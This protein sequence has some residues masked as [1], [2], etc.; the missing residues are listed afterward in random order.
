MWEFLLKYPPE[1]FSRGEI[2]LSGSAWLYAALVAAAVLVI[3]TLLRYRRAS[4]SLAPADRAVLTLARS[5]VAAILVLALFQPVLSVSNIVSERTTVA[6]LL[7]DSVSMRIADEDGAA[8]AAFVHSAFD[9]DTG[10]ISR[11]LARR[12]DPVFFRFSADLSALS[13]DREMQF[14][15]ARTEIG[16]ALE[17][18]GGHVDLQSL[19]AVVLVSDG[20]VTRGDSLDA[21]LSAYRA[22]DVPITTVG[23]G[24]PVF[25]KDVEVS[26]LSLPQRVLEGSSI[27]ADVTITQRG[28]D[29]ETV[30]LVIEDDGEPA[31]VETITFG[32]HQPVRTVR[33]RFTARDAGPRRLRFSITPAADETIV[34]NNARETL[35]DVDGAGQR[36]LY[37]EGEPRFELKF[38]RRAVAKDESLRVVTMVRTAENKYYRLGIENPQELADGFPRTAEE[39][40]AYRGLI[41][42]SVEAGYF[43]A[44]QLELIADFVSRRGG[45]LLM[46][47]GRQALSSGGYANTPVGEVLPVVLEDSR[48]PSIPVEVSVQP[49]PA[50]YG[51]PIGGIAVGADG[52][53]SWEALP[54]LKVL[55]PL[56]RAKPGAAVLLEG[57]ARDLPAPLTVLAEQRFGRG[58]AL[59][60]NVQNAWAWQMH[61]SVALE[62]QTH[63]TL[64]RQLLRWLV[65]DV[66]EPIDIRTG[67]ANPSPG[68]SVEIAAEVLDPAF[69]PQNDAEVALLVNT[70]IGDR[71]SLPMQWDAAENGVYR[72]RL[73]AEHAGLYEIA[74]EARKGETVTTSSRPLAVGTVVPDHYRAEL[75]EPLLRRIAESTGG[76]YLRAAD[77]SSLA[78][79]LPLSRSGTSVQ[80]RLALWDMPIVFLSLL[81]LIGFEWLY[82]RL[83]GLV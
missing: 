21:R 76:R 46:L 25:S 19:A 48:E 61:H 39:L 2:T 64:W 53:P 12:L 71:L 24:E 5:G 62:D 58:R 1:M 73:V 28:F 68:E 49:T 32:P 59:V 79:A 65:R 42:G 51:H 34:E 47:G 16:A 57:A 63:E 40:F 31:G 36:I 9:P 6:V 37:F 30:K 22:A 11:A 70:P 50:G 55:H 44:A 20:A 23:V 14:S 3:P 67:I 52:T 56:T 66:P 43:D 72:A 45:G 18:L 7:D 35:L 81:A 10:E 4:A 83:R 74:V 80:Q 60:L 54:P 77:A 38:L 15:G 8:R 78:D 33:A 17:E 75:R 27:V 29:G 26:A 69:R 41:L 13:S 82:R